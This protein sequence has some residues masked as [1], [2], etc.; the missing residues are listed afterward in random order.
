MRDLTI[1]VDLKPTDINSIA[2]QV[3]AHLAPAQERRQLADAVYDACGAL[4]DAINSASDIG[5]EVELTIYHCKG[6]PYPNVEVRELLRPSD[7]R[8]DS[9]GES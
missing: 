9:E 7:D 5:L 1:S 8:A 6:R 2:E 3:A 4:G